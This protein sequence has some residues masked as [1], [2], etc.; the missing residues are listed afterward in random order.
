MVCWIKRKIKSLAFVFPFWHLFLSSFVV[1]TA[2]HSCSLSFVCV[3]DKM[4]R[5]IADELHWKIR[6]TSSHCTSPKPGR[7]VI[8]GA[9]I[10]L[11]RCH[12]EPEPAQQSTGSRTMGSILLIQMRMFDDNFENMRWPE[13]LLKI[14]GVRLIPLLLPSP[15]RAIRMVW[16]HFWGAL[17]SPVYKYHLWWWHTFAYVEGVTVLSGFC[18]WPSNTWCHL[19]CILATSANR[20]L[21]PRGQHI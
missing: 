17:T 1:L 13:A 2:A 20:E 14:W 7:F 5:C 12:L 16:P 4:I 6:G 8:W 11:L 3:L 9:A 19:D 15:S 21:D 18:L 10:L